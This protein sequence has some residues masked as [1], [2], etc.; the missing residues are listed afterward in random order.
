MQQSFKALFIDFPDHSRIWMYQSDRKLNGAELVYLR[1]QLD[2]FIKD[3]AAHGKGLKASF[4]IVFDRIVL[5]CVNED[6][7]H[8]SGCS[9]DS[10]VRFMK[11]MAKELEL[12]FFD[13]LYL[14]IIDEG[15]LKRIHISDLTKYRNSMLIDPM[16]SNAGQLR[17]SGIVPVNDSVLYSQLT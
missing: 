15:D 4:D 13:R 6:A 14:Y 8:A 1:E 5:L 2:H 11:A 7:V 9:I 10:S 16:V 12:D 17:S 3:W